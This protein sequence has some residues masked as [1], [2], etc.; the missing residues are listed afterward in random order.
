MDKN[1]IIRSLKG[2]DDE[3][4]GFSLKLPVSLKNELQELCEKENI[5]MNGLIVATVQ[6][7]INDD[8]GQQTKEMKKVLLQC[9]DIVSESADKLYDLIEQQNGPDDKQDKKYHEYVS[10]LKSINTILGV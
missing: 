9:R 1:N 7:F 3:K 4:V 2:L 10:V 5:S 6:S 8:C